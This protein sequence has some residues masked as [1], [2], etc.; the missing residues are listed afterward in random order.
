MTV[1][2]WCSIKCQISV[3]V[4]SDS[5][6]NTH[7][8]EQVIREAENAARNILGKALHPIGGK[9][10]GESTTVVTMEFKDD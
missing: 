8:M 5:W 1:K 3:P 2:T 7:P 10:I 9:I 4:T 6:N